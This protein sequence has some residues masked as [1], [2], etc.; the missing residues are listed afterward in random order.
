MS[1]SIAAE[2]IALIAEDDAVRARLAADGSLFRGYHPEMEA[3]HRANAARLRAIVAASGWPTRSSVGE[4]A[5]SAAW[6]ILQHAIGEP[7]FV[8]AMVPLVRDAAARGEASAAELAMLEDRIA[9]NEG[10]LQRYGTQYDW[11]PTFTA[12]VPMIGVEEPDGVEERRRSV[13]LPPMVWRRPPPGE[14]PPGDWAARQA[15]MDAWARRC[16]WR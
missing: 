7:A 15:E 12:M 3:V 1:A 6:R 13:G 9:V 16:G 11:D 8:R 10:R 4:E 14:P 5:A 2:L